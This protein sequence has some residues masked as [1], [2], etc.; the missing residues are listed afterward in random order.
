MTYHLHQVSPQNLIL[1][2]IN[3]FDHLLKSLNFIPLQR[4]ELKGN[5]IFY[6]K[7]KGIKFNR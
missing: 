3:H 4:M 1:I 5:L 2:I 7:Y 6:N